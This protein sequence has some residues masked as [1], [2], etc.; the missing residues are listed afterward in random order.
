MGT[1]PSQYS[2]IREGFQACVHEQF[3]VRY[4]HTKEKKSPPFHQLATDTQTHSKM[5][6]TCC[7]VSVRFL[8]R[9]WFS[10]QH[11]AGKQTW[12]LR[13]PHLHIQPHSLPTKD[14][15]DDAKYRQQLNCSQKNKA[16]RA[17]IF[18]LAWNKIAAL[19]YFG[20]SCRKRS[21]CLFSSVLHC[22]QQFSPLALC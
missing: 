20:T 16:N 17:I 22:S 14:V 8:S 21:L 1:I 12:C 9:Q 13:T 3:L 2:W 6:A 18:F 7:S 5:C 10:K 15:E 4:R 19:A 11:L